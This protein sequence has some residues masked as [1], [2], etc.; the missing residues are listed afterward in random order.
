MVQACRICQGR[1]LVPFLDLGEQPHCNSF[2][3]EDQL[4]GEPRWPLKL[5]YCGGCHLVQLDC[6]VDAGLMFRN[7]LYVSGTTSTLRAHFRRTARALVARFEPP[8]GALVVDIGSND[9]TFLAGF[10]RLGLRTIG[11]DPA[12]NVAAVANRRGI[13][14]VNEF[15]GTAVASRI[16]REQGAARLITAAGV[17]FHIDDM[18]EVCRGVAELLD[19]RGVFHVQAIYLGSIL[20]QNS[21]DNIY[22]EH[23]SYYTLAPLRRL[24]ERFGLQIFDVGHS[25]IHGGSLMVYAGKPGAYPIA[26]SVEHLLAQE[27]RKGWDNLAPYLEFARRVEMLRDRLRMLLRDLRHQ[28][29]R[30]AAFGAPAKGNTL[31]NY[32]GLGPELLEYAAERAPLKIGLYTPGMHIPVIEEAEAMLDPPDYFLLLPWNFADELLAKSQAYRAAGGRF[33]IPIPAPRI[34]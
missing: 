2:L 9:G 32:C 4:V 14:T 6:V 3:R 33:I 1:E 30:V 5:L 15:F 7:Y 23:V 29:Q 17:F 26:P 8:A 24:L 20:E 12:T 16:R 27:R 18:D 11:V 28:G 22:H 34:V 10:K 21:F 19:D 13:E 31:L 25:P